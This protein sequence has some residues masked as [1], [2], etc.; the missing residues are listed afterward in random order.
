[1]TSYIITVGDDSGLWTETVVAK[2]FRIS[3]GGIL[4]LYKES[5]E[6]PVTYSKRFWKKCEPVRGDR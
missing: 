1:M 2:E 5:L 3:D 4:Y 6:D